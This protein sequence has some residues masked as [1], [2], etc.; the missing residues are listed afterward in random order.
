MTADKPAA[1]PP[2]STSAAKEATIAAIILAGGSSRRFGKDN[3]LLADIDGVPLI[4]HVAI[5]VLRSRAGR[6]LVVTG[7]Q[8]EAVVKALAGLDLQCV[9]NPRHMD[10]MGTTVAAGVKALPESVQAVLITP[11]DLPEIS[12]PLIDRLIA[13]AAASGGE[14]IVFPTL[15]SGEQRNPVLWPRRYFAELAVLSGDSGARGL[16]KKYEVQGLPVQMTA[17]DVFADIDRPE[18]L[19]TWRRK[20]GLRPV[21]G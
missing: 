2:V 4:R 12:A 1:S 8:Q 11:G 6:V 10:G 5:Q 21:G 9:H 14:R 7:H 18:D 20:R 17:L 15:P 3:K 13:I 16:V 19:E